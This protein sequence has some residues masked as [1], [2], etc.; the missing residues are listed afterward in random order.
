MTGERRHK[1]CVSTVPGRAPLL[2]ME[3]A[4]VNTQQLLCALE[5][6]HNTQPEDTRPEAVCSWGRGHVP[7]GEETL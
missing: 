4:P 6:R 3:Q 2:A 5:P 1:M 7:P